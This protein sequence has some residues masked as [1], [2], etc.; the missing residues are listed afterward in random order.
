M[1]VDILNEAAT[2]TLIHFSFSNSRYELSDHKGPESIN[3]TIVKYGIRFT[4]ATRH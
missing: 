4:A 1:I 2:V 3:S